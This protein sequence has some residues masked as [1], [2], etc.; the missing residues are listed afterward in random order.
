MRREVEQFVECFQKFGDELEKLVD[1]LGDDSPEAVIRAS[2]A[3]AGMTTQN[4]EHMPPDA[5]LA[6]VNRIVRVADGSQLKFLVLGAVNAMIAGR[7]IREIP[8]ELRKMAGYLR[9]FEREKAAAADH[10]S[11]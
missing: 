4:V 10:L 1:E 11:N 8:Q 7:T 2:I 5:Q 6:L 3:V 9:Q